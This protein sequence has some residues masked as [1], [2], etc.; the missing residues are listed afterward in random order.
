MEEALLGLI[1]LIVHGT[2]AHERDM[3]DG[4]KA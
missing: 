4:N 2:A 1:K 3:L